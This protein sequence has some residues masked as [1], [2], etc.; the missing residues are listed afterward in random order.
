MEIDD[1]Q[2]QEYLDKHLP[3]RLNSLLA[4]DLITFRRT[5]NISQELK[6]K[7]YQDSL[8]LEPAF[9]IS[10]IFGRSL[11]NFLGIT[12]DSKSKKLIKYSP[13][14]D[15]ISL[16]NIYPERDFCPLTEDLI[17]EN[18]ESLC[19]IIKLANKSVAHLT[20]TESNANEHSL[21]ENARKTIYKLTL[22][23][24]PD[25]NKKGIWWHEQV[26]Q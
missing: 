14:S 18:Y 12:Y 8:V 25:I 21:L 2:K 23:Y 15:D 17:V 5:L 22:K 9:E 13:K 20:S 10:I 6:L 26:G 4:P 24:V 3:Y 7:C 16:I 11:L 19:T 1:K